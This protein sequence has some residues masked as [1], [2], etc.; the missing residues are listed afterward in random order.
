MR[1]TRYHWEENA[2]STAVL[3]SPEAP[4]PLERLL[5]VADVAALPSELPS[6][7]VRYELD[8]GRLIV[9]PPAGDTHGALE[10]NIA[11]ELKLQGERRGLGK[12]RCGDVG[13]ILRRN[14]DRLVG[15]D[16]AFISNARLPLKHSPEGYLE[17]IPDLV[18]EV[19]SKTETLPDVEKKVAEYLA[20]GVRVVWV[21]DPRGPA[22]T[23]YR[24][25][26]PPRAFSPG[27]TLTVEDVIPGFSLA[28]ADVF[29]Q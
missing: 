1:V 5:T 18:V 8:D 22:L 29:R 28:V 26:Q 12:T 14:P 23:E 17:T 13:I 21:V 6:G 19:R 7:T 15:A 9:M 24:P 3:T 16:A 20:A 4:P 27:D 2:V 10:S 25:G 11:T